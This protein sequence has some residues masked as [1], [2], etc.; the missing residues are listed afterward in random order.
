ME[1]DGAVEMFLQSIDKNN[2]KYTE[3]IGDGDSNSFGAVKKALAE[4]YGDEYVVRKQDC[5]GHIQKRM[6]SA[7][8]TCKNNCNGSVLSD[9]KTAG[10]VEDPQIKLLT[11]YKHIMDMQS[12]II[13]EMMK[14]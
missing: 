7:L 4:K 1:R 3:Y 14:K 9:G 12:E 13:K 5:I 8:K 10:G 11:R 2:L 6:G